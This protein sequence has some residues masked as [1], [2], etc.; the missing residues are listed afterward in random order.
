MVKGL[1]GWEGFVHLSRVMRISL[2][3]RYL[4]RDHEEV[5]EAS[6]LIFGGV[7]GE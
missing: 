4:N 3:C 7:R 5:K 6:M 1:Q 2:I